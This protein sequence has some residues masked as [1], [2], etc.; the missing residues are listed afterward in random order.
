MFQ[1]GNKTNTTGSL[2][3]AT[4]TFPTLPLVKIMMIR[5]ED[6]EEEEDI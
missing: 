4:L 2:M 1:L 3:L 5:I 6:L